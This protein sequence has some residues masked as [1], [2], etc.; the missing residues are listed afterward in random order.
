MP[1]SKRTTAGVAGGLLGLIG[2][3]TV[4]GVLITATVTPA[5]AVT[6]AAATSAIDMFNNLPS[7]LNI[8]K[9]ILPSTIYYTDGKKSVKMATYY[10]Q[11]R[12]PVTFKQIAPV[13]YDALLSSEDPRFYEHGGIDIM[14]TTRAI[15]SNVKG[16]S[17]TQGG[18]SISQ[19]YVKNVKVQECDWD[20][21]NDEE[22]NKCWREATD[23]S[24]V[25]GYQR[26]LQEMRYAIALEQ[27]YSKNDILLGYMNI[28]NFGGTTYG[29]D[30]AAMRYFGV[31]A[32]KLN[33]AQAATLAGMVQNPNTYRIDLP[34]GTIK[35]RAGKPVNTAKDGYKLTKQR[36]EYVLG[37]M[38]EDGKITQKQHDD[39]VKAP[40]VPKVTDPSMGCGESIAPYFC[41]YVT[42]V[43][44]NDPA[45]GDKEQRRQLLYKGGLKIYTTLDPRIQKASAKAQKDYTPTTVTVPAY[46]KTKKNPDPT[47]GSASVSV[48]VDT[49]RVLAITQNTKYTA[50]TSKAK[51][52]SGIVYA[53]DLQFGGSGGF[54]AGSTFK[55]FTLLDWLDKGKSLNQ[56]LDG[57]KH[58]RTPWTDRCVAGGSL[59]N[60]A[61]VHNYQQRGGY[62]GTPMRFTKESLNTGFLE[63]A[64]QLDLCDIGNVAQSLGV[65]RGD[66]S[67][68][69]LTTDGTSKIQADNPVPYEVIGSDNVSP[70]AM[71]GAYAAVANKGVYCQPRV[72]D[73]IVDSEGND[74]K[75]P[76]RSCKQV[77]DPKVAATAAYA[78]KGPLE[79]GG[80]GDVGNPNDGTP[81]IG[82]TGTHEDYQ[83][84]LMTSSTKVTTANWVGSSFGQLDLYHNYFQ[85]VSLNNAR[86]SLGRSIQGA[87][88]KYY[89][90]GDFPQPDNN[91]LRTVKVNLP[92]VIG[93]SQDDA[94][95][96]LKKAGFQVT[97]GKPV[98]SDQPKGLVAEQ[99]PGAGRVAAGTAVTL[100]LSTGQ[101]KAI[102]DVTGRVP[103]EAIA[104]LGAAGF[105][106][107]SLQCQTNPG[108]DGTVTSTDPSAGTIAGPSKKIT[109]TYQSPDCKGGGGGIIPPP[110][111]GHGGNGGN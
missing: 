99:S 67:P 68:I 28:A 42:Q 96:T 108:G 21:K 47:F 1:H 77:I 59:G 100:Q 49:G 76:D 33:L 79:R 94:E 27:K 62:F 5:V 4:A 46:Q 53:G 89:K 92:S 102:P 63:M 29:I 7:V 88:D 111:K 101:G 85:G 41:Q 73:K 48:E 105:T 56:V 52:T 15:L 57:R 25:E 30:A 106:R 95:K 31:H 19:Q 54:N 20:A 90:G 66:G 58:N 70:M 35:D 103:A 2:L 13:M 64:R 36:Q 50:G 81:L 22:L 32:S 87:I 45:F 86:F 11:N 84:W 91:L 10:D 75:L 109:V 104:I 43:M 44:R 78:L 39:A 51:G 6:S 24:G 12:S 98:D 80:S 8:G 71:A 23:S 69:P 82:K 40:I 107:T 9:Q 37:R 83:T 93:M 61:D 74:V 3:S 34:G 65:M 55:L 110:G 72:I 16:G 17:D 38:L 60:N 18:S 14:G 26:K 97:I